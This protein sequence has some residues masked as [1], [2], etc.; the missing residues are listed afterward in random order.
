MHSERADR[1]GALTLKAAFTL[2]LGALLLLNIVDASAVLIDR[3]DMD[4]AALEAARQA[5]ASPAY[6]TCADIERAAARRLCE[7]QLT[8][9]AIRVYAA[10]T[11]G[12]DIGSLA[13]A[14]AG[15]TV[16]VQID[17]DST[18]MLCRS[19]LL[20]NRVHLSVLALVRRGAD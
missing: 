6:Y 18:P 17:A 10:D 20:R 15:A 3:R 1:G 13:T 16:A 19:G 4:R 9:V 8:N 2:I 7:S 14:P 12:H 11:A 5:A